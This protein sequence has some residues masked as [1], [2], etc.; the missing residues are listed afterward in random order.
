MSI[1]RKLL[2][3]VT[4]VLLIVVSF[5]LFRNT[6]LIYYFEKK[7]ALLLSQSGMRLTV[8]KIG[9]KGLRSIYIENLN[10]VPENADMLIYLEKAQIKLSLSKMLR[11]KIGF[12]ELTVDTLFVNAVKYND[13]TTN[14]SGLL[15]GGNKSNAVA[16]GGPVEFNSRFTTILNKAGTLF[17]GSAVLH[18]VRISYSADGRTELFSI[19]ELVYD[20]KILKSS[21]ITSSSDG[22]GN[23]KVDGIVDVY[24][25]SYDF[26]IIK[27][28]KEKSCLPFFDL[29]DNFKVGFDSLHL[30][31]KADVDAS[32][33]PLNAKFDFTGL[34]MNH[35]R[36]S[37]VDVLLSDMQMDFKFL[38]DNHRITLDKG[39]N[40]RLEKLPIYIDGFL[41]NSPSV[42]V[43]GNIAF[44]CTANDFYSSLPKGMFKTLRGM[45]A[46]GNLKYALNFDIDKSNPDALVF[47]SS[48]KKD[49]FRIIK[50]GDEYFPKIN[51]DF[52]F[53]AMDKDKPVRTF[54]VGTSNQMFTPYAAISGYLKNAVLTSEDPGF[55]THNGFVESAFRESI[56]TNLKEGRFARGGSTISMQLVKNIFLSRNK[57]VA[58]KLEEMLIVW[59]IEQNRLVSKERMF[60]VYL[61]IIEWGPGI[62]GIGEASHFYF[63]KKPQELNLPESVFLASII[64]HPKYFKYMFDST[65]ALK[66]NQQGFY[67][68]I[69]NRLL[70]RNLIS[71]D[72]IDKADTLIKVTGDA[73]RLIMPLDSIPKDSLELEEM[74]IGD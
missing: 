9:F 24:N 57:T 40:L 72:E 21:F 28:D 50:F 62:Y 51:E 8:G 31:I 27:T 36:I 1:D 53:T 56:A 29:F 20:K 6:V 14:Y 68:L 17:N 44:N 70:S 65:G 60:E 37:P 38:I 43:G 18:A 64:P 4:A 45:E 42:R 13:S 58:R 19:P 52:E 22:T 23:Y 49:R 41:E 67:R 11:L 32:T 55:M 15:K 12:N 61:N 5:F 25:D 10:L 54:T 46:S 30:N 35:W 7:K 3:A 66:E 33:I 34:R 16:T 47:E 59:L 74:I 48:L 69:A 2:I 63:N 71:Q 26:M 39:T 73:F